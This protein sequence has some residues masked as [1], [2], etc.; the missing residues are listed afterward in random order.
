MKTIYLLLFT[1]VI[2]MNASADDPLPSWNEGSSKQAIVDFVARVT[3]EGSESFVAVADRIAVFDNDGTLWCEYPLPNQATFA[4]DEIKRMLPEHPEWKDEPAVA[5]LLSGD[6]AAL[7][8]DH[9][10]G[11]IK[12]LAMTHAGLSTNE[13]DKRV[14]N[15][16]ASSKHPKFGC[17]Y[18]QVIYQPMVEVLDYLRAN[19]FETWIVSGGG[20]DFMRVFAEE[21]YG[22]PRQQVVGSH[23]R[24]S[25]ELVDGIPTLTKT[26]D[27]LFVDEKEGK[28]V[29][30]ELFIGRRPI[31]CFGNSNGDQAMMEYTTMDNPLSSFGLIVHHTDAEREYAY[32]ANPTSSGKLTTALEVAPQRGWTVV[33]MKNDWKTV[34]P[35]RNS[36]TMNDAASNNEGRKQLMGSWLVED[37]NG[38]G[39]IDRAQTTIELKVD[40]TF[41]GSTCVNRYSGKADIASGKVSLGS[42]TTTRRAGPPA[43]MDQE[44]KF[45][46]AIASVAAYQFGEPGILLFF[47]DNG[48]Q[49]MRLSRQ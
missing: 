44:Q 12:L 47:D 9:H 4:S 40:G 3:T 41:S 6:A 27:S 5:A 7:L 10:A 34:F 24:M 21:T 15:W 28:P 13:F 33:D 2:S 25:Y 14:E 26:M 38:R 32:D 18:K 49:M 45:L 42:L 39:V 29:A 22:I 11:L 8:A 16:L 23:A 30:I 46:K 35:A 36:L 17:S 48:R 20:Q 37:I 43:M 1:V 31:A 19:D